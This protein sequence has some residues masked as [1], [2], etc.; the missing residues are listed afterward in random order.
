MTIDQLV[1]TQT[2]IRRIQARLPSLKEA[3]AAAA[4]KL[5]LPESIGYK[6]TIA[7]MQARDAETA[8]AT[9][10]L[11]LEAL[12]TLPA[13]PDS[14]KYFTRAQADYLLLCEAL[15]I[16]RMDLEANLILEVEETAKGAWKFSSGVAK[17]SAKVKA[18]KAQIAEHDEKKQR[19]DKSTEI[20]TEV[21]TYMRLLETQAAELSAWIADSS[22]KP[23]FV[24]EDEETELAAL[25]ASCTVI[26]K[27]GCRDCPEEAAPDT[28]WGV[29]ISA[30]DSIQRLRAEM[31]PEVEIKEQ[32]YRPST[33]GRG[34]KEWRDMFARFTAVA[35]AR[36]LA[37]TKADVTSCATVKSLSERA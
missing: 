20:T 37:K 16:E 1:S 17:D 36:R 25:H 28:E 24:K 11:A 9:E 22:L 33:T 2:E 3:V 15:A 29:P 30:T 13:G 14:L 4:V 18:L 21:L 12:E 6:A 31:F 23:D 7:K 27:S 19:L 32:A 5:T 34:T 10:C 8:L 26:R 35:V